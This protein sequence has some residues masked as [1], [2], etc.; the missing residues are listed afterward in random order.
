MLAGYVFLLAPFYWLWNGLFGPAAPADWQ[1]VV[2]FQVLLIVAMRWLVDNHF[3][4]SVVSAFLH[5]IGFSFL[6]LTALY[7]G[8]RQ[9]V[10]KGVHW[11]NRLY[12]QASG[13]N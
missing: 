5:P 10:G 3:K 1:L 2:V 13:V 7:A 8:A 4:E 6:F 9:A 11:K 12:G